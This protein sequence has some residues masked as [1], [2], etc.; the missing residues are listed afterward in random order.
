MPRAHRLRSSATTPSPSTSQ[1][2]SHLPRH[3]FLVSPPRVL[4]ICP[5]GS[6][7]RQ[8]AMAMARSVRQLHGVCRGHHHCMAAAASAKVPTRGPSSVSMVLMLA[9]PL[10]CI[11][12]V[13]SSGSQSTLTP[14]AGASPCVLSFETR[15]WYRARRAPWPAYAN[16]V[17]VPR[18]AFSCGA[19]SKMSTMLLEQVSQ[20]CVFS[21][22]TLATG[23][24]VRTLMSW[25]PLSGGPRSLAGLRG[26]RS[27]LSSLGRQSCRIACRWHRRTGAGSPHP[28]SIVSQ[29]VSPSYPCVLA[30]APHRRRRCR[31]APSM[32]RKLPY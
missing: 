25:P 30:H 15:C 3:I 1:L 14:G 17:E 6:R 2:S 23:T 13:S 26:C 7:W 28:N 31:A 22:T 10:R 27:R 12:I 11:S 24:I 18:E 5:R 9:G 8:R 29:G 21:H 19:I 32:M 16:G 4:Y 20:S